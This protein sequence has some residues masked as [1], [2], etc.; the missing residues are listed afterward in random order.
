MLTDASSNCQPMPFAQRLVRR[1]RQQ[2]LPAFC[3]VFAQFAGDVHLIAV[4]V[5]VP[6]EECAS[7]PDADG[8][9]DLTGGG[10]DG[11]FAISTCICTSAAQRRADAV[12]EKRAKMLSASMRS[13][14]PSWASTI[15]TTTRPSLSSR[16]R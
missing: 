10:Q 1:G 4:C 2:D 12:S 14:L 15:G 7:V 8:D 13:T 11:S 16:A 3:Q 9:V 6:D 5:V